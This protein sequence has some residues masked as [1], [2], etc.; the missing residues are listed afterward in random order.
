ME[1][2]P[3]AISVIEPGKSVLVQCSASE[4][5]PITSMSSNL[6][7]HHLYQPVSDN[8]R[9]VNYNT[10]YTHGIIQ[11]NTSHG[12]FKKVL[13]LTIHTIALNYLLK[14]TSTSILTN[15]LQSILNA[16][17]VPTRSQSHPI[18]LVMPIS[19]IK[20]FSNI[21]NVNINTINN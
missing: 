2:T 14:Q 19:I 17:M 3:F 1:T 21:S 15:A 16:R 10:F 8:L 18:D 9:Y 11:P 7:H 5:Q 12:F 20:K 13:T 4:L 6:K